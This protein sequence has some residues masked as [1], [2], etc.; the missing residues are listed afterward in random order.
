MAN[1]AYSFSP[2]TCRK[3]VCGCVAVSFP[4]WLLDEEYPLAGC[5]KFLQ[6]SIWLIHEL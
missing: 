3:W 5:P 1:Y 4:L 2:F 6:F